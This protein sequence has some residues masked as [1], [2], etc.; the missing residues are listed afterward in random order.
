MAQRVDARNR[1]LAQVATLRERNRFGCAARFL[2]EIVAGQ[3]NAIKW[4]A[5]QNTLGVKHFRTGSN[6]SSLHQ[7]T[8][9]P[10]QQRSNGG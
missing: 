5:C 8:P 6:R 2:R 10:R 4:K 1:L 9:E 3:I 7:R